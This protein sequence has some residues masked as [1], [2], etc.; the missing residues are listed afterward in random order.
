M[1]RPEGD[2]RAEADA[3]KKKNRQALNGLR[4]GLLGLRGIHV[5]KS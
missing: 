2:K 5:Q 4:I 1:H 3:K